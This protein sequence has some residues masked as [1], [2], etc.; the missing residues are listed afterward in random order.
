MWRDCGKHRENIMKRILKSVVASGKSREES[1]TVA[2]RLGGCGS[3][4]YGEALNVISY[5]D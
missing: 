1:R 3:D 2:A 4:L 5:I